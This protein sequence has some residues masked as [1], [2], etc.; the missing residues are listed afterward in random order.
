MVLK[1]K[2]KEW[3]NFWM[4]PSGLIESWSLFYNSKFYEVFSRREF[5]ELKKRLRLDGKQ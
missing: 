4:T 2:H 5:T 3:Y 1:R